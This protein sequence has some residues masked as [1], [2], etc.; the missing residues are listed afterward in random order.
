MLSFSMLRKSKF[1]WGWRAPARAAEPRPELCS[2]MGGRG[3][4][5]LCSPMGRELLYG[6]G[7]S[8]AGAAGSPPPKPQGDQPQLMM[9]HALYLQSWRQ[10][11]GT[12]LTTQD[13][14][15]KLLCKADLTKY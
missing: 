4:P 9:V 14:H 10:V 12:A 5:A 15:P 3:G 8:R 6:P 1:T 7:S 13:E 11:W 2:P